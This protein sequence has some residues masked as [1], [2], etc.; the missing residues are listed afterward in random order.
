MNET[1]K[2]YLLAA[3]IALTL[4]ALALSYFDVLVK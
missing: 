1:I 4:T 3:T 2:D